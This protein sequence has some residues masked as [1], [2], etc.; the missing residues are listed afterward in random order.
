MTTH[1]MINGNLEEAY[2]LLN[3]FV[4][5]SKEDTRDIRLMMREASNDIDTLDHKIKL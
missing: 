5:E 4:R 3:L 1:Q 2:E